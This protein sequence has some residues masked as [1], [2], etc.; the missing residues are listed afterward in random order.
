MRAPGRLNSLLGTDE[1]RV[2]IVWAVFAAAAAASIALLGFAGK[3]QTLKS[4]EWG[5]AIRLDTQPL[6]HAV[7]EPPAGRYLLALPMLLYKGAFSTIGIAH[8]LPYRLA[9]MALTIATAGLFLVFAARRV[10]YVVALPAAVLLLFLGSAGEV[11]STPLRIPEQIAVIA[12]LGMLLAFERHDSRGDVGACVLLLV[13]ITS[14]PLGAAFLAAAAVL[15]LSR[16]SP[17]RWQRAW[18]FAV[19]GVLF[20]AWYFTLRTPVSG[21]PP[22]GD[23]LRDV[24]RFA[25]ESLS[26]MA[27]A[28]TGVFRSP[29]GGRV[30]FLTPLTYALAAGV[31]AAA[32]LRA[33]TARMPASF[34][35]IVAAMLVLFAAPAFAPGG[36]RVPESSRYIFSGVVMLLLLLSE[37]ARGV[38]LTSSRSRMA[39]AGAAAG[40]F[41]FSMYSNI[42]ALKGSAETWATRGLQA[43]AEMA[44]TDLAHGIVAP[45]FLPGNPFAQPRIPPTYL[46]ISA[47]D[48]FALARDY[49]TPAFSPAQL[50]SQSAPT[51]RV[52]DIVLARALSLHLEPVRSLPRTA[53]A[54]PRVISTTADARDFR[55]GCVTLVPG[56]EPASSQIALPDGGVAVAAGSG[57][58]VNLALARFGD[59]YDFPL[60]SVS[61]G[62]RALLRI[63]TDAAPAP[64]RLLIHKTRQP[65]ILC[66]LS[67]AG[68]GT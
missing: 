35:A 4:D 27:A 33:I 11:T 1:G 66:G 17:Q 68:Q 20:A 53:R 49:G 36:L 51:R 14:H 37:L 12:G 64:W 40:I 15:V 43:R 21:R 44:A 41:A 42:E 22:L 58:P 63:P 23:E 3:G 29:F 38:S 46:T 18:V 67:G 24:P 6:L 61:P 5:Y 48:Y 2:W 57:E 52:A 60:A 45:S 62:R 34:W 54:R 31:L 30:D 26:A 16:P 9:G 25:A 10:G 13:S 39:V 47:G 7:F 50:G 56:D 59:A 32:G 19:P 8:Y 28:A 55:Q 65:V